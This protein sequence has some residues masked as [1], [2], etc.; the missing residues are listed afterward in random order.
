MP[1]KAGIQLPAQLCKDRRAYTNDMDD[2]IDR[3]RGR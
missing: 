1:A 3:L 2:W